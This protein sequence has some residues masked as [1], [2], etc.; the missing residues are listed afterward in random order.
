MGHPK[1]R[2]PKYAIID[3]SSGTA[4]DYPISEE[5]YKKYI[6]GKS[7]GSRLLFDLAP[8]RVDPLSADNVIIVNTSPMTG[9]GAASTSRFNLSFKNVLTGG[10]ATSN[11]GGTFGIMLKAAGYDGIILKGKA[12]RPSYIEIVDGAISL[13]NAEHLWGMN[14]EEVQE[15]F[16]PHWGKLVIGPAGE[17]LVRYA[18]AVSGERVAGR[19]GAGA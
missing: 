15:Q 19:C 18:S 16:E 10:I 1:L 6:G 7:L 8:P 9:T 13:K 2:L 4:A 12:E 17:N 14:T 5:L 11:C 3:L